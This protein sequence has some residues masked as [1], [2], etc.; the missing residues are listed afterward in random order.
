MNKE[1][2]AELLN[3]REIGNEITKD[4]IKIAKENNLVVVFGASD[5]LMEFEGAISEEFGTE[6][7]FNKDGSFIERCDDECV[8]YK[9][10]LENA[11]KIEADYTKNGWRYKTE[12]P[13]VTF[14]IMEDGELYCKGIVFSL[15]DCK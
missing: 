7:E 14:D 6:A 8:H 5:D 12:I 9:K 1:Q 15:L 10:A 4:E 2:L 13:H 3:G 11:N